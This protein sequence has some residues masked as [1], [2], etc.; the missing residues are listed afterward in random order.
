[1]TKIK[2]PPPQAVVFR[3]VFLEGS[4]LFFQTLGHVEPDQESNTCQ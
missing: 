2:K 4:I 1:M 3:L